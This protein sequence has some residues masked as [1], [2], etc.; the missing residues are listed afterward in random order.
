MTLIFAPGFFVR[1]IDAIVDREDTVLPLIAVITS[2][3]T[4][5]ADAA[6][7]P[8]RVPAI[9]PTAAGAV[10]PKPFPNCGCDLHAQECH[11]TYVHGC[12]GLA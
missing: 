12:R 10:P 4:M 1:M 8:A 2:P 11:R 9:T 6:G 5:P 7:P 3:A